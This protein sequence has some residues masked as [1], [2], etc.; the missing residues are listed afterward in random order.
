MCYTQGK[1]DHMKSSH[2]DEALSLL[3]K[4]K[5]KE[6][7]MPERKK[8]SMELAALMLDES[9]KTMTHEEKKTQAQLAK[10]MQDPLGKPFTTALTDQCFR[11][12]SYWKTADKM[13]DLFNH[14]GIPQYLNWTQRAELLFFKSL[15]PSIAQA[16][17][18]IVYHTMRKETERVIL[19]AEPSLLNRH[20]EE[21]R[22]ENVR[23]NINHLGEAI[24]SEAEAKRRL[25]L[26][27]D[28]LQ[29]PNIDYISIKI[30]TIFSQI[31]LLDFEGTLEKISERLK[32]LY[33]MAAQSSVTLPD[34][35]K[36]ARFV[37]LDMEEYRDL[38]LT[39]AAFKRVLSEEEFFSYSA[40][41]VLQAYLPDSHN[42]QKDI[43][44]W[45]KE[46]VAKGG[47]PVKL[48]I[49]KGANLAMEQFEASLRGWQQAPYP[50]KV[51]VDAN[52]KRM[53][54]YGTLPENAKAI[55]LGVASHNLFDLAFAMLLRSERQ[56]ESY[57]GFEMLE[58][59]ADHIRRVVQ[60]LTGDVLLYCPVAKKEDF[61]H[62]IAYLIRRLDENTGAENFLRHVF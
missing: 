60:K 17:V 52:Y 22:K 13:I 24:L 37:N 3:N 39:V 54:L 6:L 55:R 5:G 25:Q 28:D 2:L 12:H 47:A 16:L 15:N 33:R 7:S 14:V 29:H 62:A 36:R 45:A 57:V 50:C 41:V 32:L 31:N 56:V 38:D 8:L 42:I 1:D 18:P 44:E 9:S 19:P 11:S 35:T 48:R 34:G 26:Y 4:V 58:G 46:R 53:V 20:I 59:M 21:R 61:Q 10:L 51:E 43:T 27:L 49:V 23:L 30:S 40:G